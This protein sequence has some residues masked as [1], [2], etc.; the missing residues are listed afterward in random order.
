MLVW[1]VD[2]SLVRR[3]RILCVYE[4][5]RLNILMTCFHIREIR[6]CIISVVQSVYLTHSFDLNDSIQKPEMI[7][8]LWLVPSEHSNDN[9]PNRNNHRSHNSYHHFALLPKNF[10]IS[11]N[12]TKSNS[13]NA[14]HVH[15]KN[16]VLFQ[17]QGFSRFSPLPPLSMFST[18]NVVYL[19][20]TM[21]HVHFFHFG[22]LGVL[23]F[24]GE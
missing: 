3:K 22:L 23:R 2:F 12:S 15:T 24:S 11:T 19:L 16:S 5:T 9:E 21:R 1:Q 4:C 18:W 17:D 14:I 8:H 13:Q 10:P 7:Q 20:K 6:S